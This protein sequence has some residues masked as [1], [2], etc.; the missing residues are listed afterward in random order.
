[1]V[2]D[3]KWLTGLDVAIHSEM[4]RISES[5]THRVK[6]LVDRYETPVSKIA[7]HVA[8]LEMKVS[9]YLVRMGFVWT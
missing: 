8:D 2:V 6:E 1:M 4:E 5:L 3:G 7:K 9:R